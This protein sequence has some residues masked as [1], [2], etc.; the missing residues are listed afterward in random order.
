MAGQKL[1]S[2]VDTVKIIKEILEDNC[3]DPSEAMIEMGQALI[4]VGEALKGKSI[5]EARNIMQ[6]VSVLQ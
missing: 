4:K 3:H 5:N 1:N 2:K 6:A